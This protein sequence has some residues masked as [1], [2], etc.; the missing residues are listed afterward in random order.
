MMKKKYTSHDKIIK[1]CPSY[2][3]IF[4]KLSVSLILVFRNI[5]FLK[6]INIGTIDI[7]FPLRYIHLQ[8]IIICFYM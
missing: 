2:K 1:H 6:K 3:N 5:F 4:Y 7:F 8:K